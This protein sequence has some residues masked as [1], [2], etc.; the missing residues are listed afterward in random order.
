LNIFQRLVGTFFDPGN[1]FR[2]ITDHPVWI[3]ALIIVLI[4]ISVYSY[5]IFP[6]TT[7]ESLQMMNDSAAKLKEKWGEKG[8]QTAVERVKNRSRELTSFLMAPLTYLIG[9]LFSAL[10]IFGL[11]RTGSTQGNYRQVFALLVH[12]NFVDKLLGNAVRLF[13]ASSRGSVFQTTTGAAVFFPGLEVTSTTYAILNQMDFFQL[14]LFG[15]FGLGLAKTFRIKTRKAMVISFGFWLL[16][17]TLS[18]LFSIVQMKV[19]R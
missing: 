10:I 6:L 11:G 4:L 17:S 12:A 1:T 18:F 8:F 5:M 9:F 19:F 7:Q 2:R 14:W 13:L 16:K 3:D 15:I